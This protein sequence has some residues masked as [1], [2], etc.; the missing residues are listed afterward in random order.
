MDALA[1][2]L[3]FLVSAQ[4]L[5]E[6]SSCIFLDYLTDVCHKLLRMTNMYVCVCDG[7]SIWFLGMT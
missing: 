2:I 6:N 4:S 1:V 3:F 7:F 5:L